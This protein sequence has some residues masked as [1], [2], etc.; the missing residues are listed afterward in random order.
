MKNFVIAISRG[1]GSGGSHVAGKIAGQLGISC[2][3][4]E[5]LQ[6]AADLSG[7]NERYFFEA[8]EKIR[9]NVIA[10][11]ASKGVY[12]GRVYPVSD[13]KY[14]SD[15]NFFNFQAQVI[16]EL[17]EQGR[18]SCIIIGK[19]ANY[20]LRDYDNAVRI[21]IQAPMELCLSNIMERLQKSR[22]E[23]EDVIMKTNK[24]RSNYYKYFTGHNW[25]DPAQY[26]LSINTKAL[27]EDY[28]AGLIIQLVKD[29][30]FLA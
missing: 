2:Y 8:N 19:A 20:V 16:K 10:I 15:K 1:Y 18:E 4:Q 28:T 13:K 5:I 3:D 9:K 23:A 29:R 7:I 11:N 24:Y 25:L 17:A 30:G 12:D 27:G 14:L 6:M 22:S 21:N 26:D